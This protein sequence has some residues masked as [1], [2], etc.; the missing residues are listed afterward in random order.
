MER[1]LRDNGISE[2]DVKELRTALESDEVPKKGE[3]FGP[4]VS[5]WIGKMMGKAADGSWKIAVEV[6]ANVLA[7]V[8]GAYYGFDV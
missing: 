7:K 5:A 1:V 2:D 4:K 3:S 6:G 8:I